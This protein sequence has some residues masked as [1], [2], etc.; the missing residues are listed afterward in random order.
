MANNLNFKWGLHA[1]L[2][3]GTSGKRVE[4][5]TLYFTKD[6]GG[7]YLGVAETQKPKRIQGV[8]QYYADLTQFKTDV[9]PPY[10][11]D[12]IY[13][14]ASENALVKWTG[15]TIGSDGSIQSGAFTVL[16]VTAS[17]FAG[18]TE[19]VSG[20]T[21]AINSLRADLGNKDEN[22]APAFDRIISLE[23]AVSALEEFV[24]SGSEGDSLA[25]RI[26]ALET[27][28]IDIDDWAVNY[29]NDTLTS[30]GAA[31][32]TNNGAINSLR[33]DL[34]NST[35]PANG[36]AF[37][38][39]ETVENILQ[40]I[41]EYIGRDDGKKGTLTSRVS[42]LESEVSDLQSWSVDVDSEISDLRSDLD[43][44]IAT[45]NNLGTVVDGIRKDLGT[46]TFGTSTAFD[47][48]GRLITNEAA[49]S[50]RVDG[51]DKSIAAVTTT[52]NSAL[53]QANANKATLEGLTGNLN[54]NYYTKD[55]VNGFVQDL[56]TDISNLE[57]ELSDRIDDEIKAA[58][59]LTYKG[60][61]DGDATWQ[62]ICTK[63]SHIGDTYVV[64]NGTFT[65]QNF[66][67]ANNYAVY[68]GDLIVATAKSN[69]SGENDDGELV[70]SNTYWVHVKTGYD[71]TFEG[72]LTNRV[73][74]G[75]ISFDL[76][77]LNGTGTRGDLGTAYIRTQGNIK[78]GTD[79]AGIPQLALE[80][81]TF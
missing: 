12:V 46:N 54:G 26:A 47:Q 73:D 43:N 20:N 64:T 59:A 35:N 7:L 10:S 11:T 71:K 32:E 68:A 52:A 8:V 34:G 56:D 13:Y 76:T 63:S 2:P 51:H 65:L 29:V 81:G 24:G 58:N 61:I 42:T 72:K 60:G 57:A 67:G 66:N 31:I 70:V 21:G 77:S 15:E 39:I 38:R 62:T 3:D 79:S 37:K 16:N 44:E 4:V 1:N 78:A 45:R 18:L 41:D 74:S 23:A 22:G 30:H 27:W 69:T 48:I 55:E 36:T 40:D 9:V 19:V 5:G 25:S 75:Y 33:A 50:G 28:R 49:L 6:E 17:D 80:W 14:I 53:A